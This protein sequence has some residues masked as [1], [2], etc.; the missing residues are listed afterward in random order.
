MEMVVL[1]I[2]IRN[3]QKVTEELCDKNFS[4]ATVFETF[5]ELN[6]LVIKF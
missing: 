5:K 4:K 6:I 1:G 3:I 2:S